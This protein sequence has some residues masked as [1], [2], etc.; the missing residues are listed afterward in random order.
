MKV[1]ITKLNRPLFEAVKQVITEEPRRLDMLA[2]LRTIDGTNLIGSHDFPACK[3]VGCLAGWSCVLQDAGDAD[4]FEKT[5]QKINHEEPDENWAELLIRACD[6][7]GLPVANHERKCNNFLFSD[8]E[9]YKELFH[10]SFWPKQFRT[11]YEELNSVQKAAR[12][13][14]RIDY[15]LET[16]Q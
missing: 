16:G 8:G 7:L 9:P 2:G 1:D 5:A 10:V 13:C 4:L 3:T 14:A 11:G 6:N 15:L 12:V